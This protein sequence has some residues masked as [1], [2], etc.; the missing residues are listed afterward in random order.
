MSQNISDYLDD[1]YFGCGVFVDLRKAF[2]TVDHKILLKKL[3][4]YGIRGIALNLLSSY[5]TNRYQFCYSQW[6]FLEKSSCKT[7]SSPRICPWA[8]SI[9]HI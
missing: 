8:S 3:H 6:S 9:S 2:D 7:W 4:H 1:G 5:L